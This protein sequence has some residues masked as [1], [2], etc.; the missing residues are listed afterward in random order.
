[1]RAF[2]LDKK[3]WLS[4]AILIIAGLFLWQ[5][6]DA[7]LIDDLK[8]VI[9]E[10]N[11]QIQKLEEEAQRYRREIAVKQ[12]E[13]QT[14]RSEIGQI[15]QVVG[16]LKREIAVTESKVERTELELKA[17]TI[18]IQDKEITIRKLRK[19]LAG[20]VLAFFES[21]QKP[22]FAILIHT[23]VLSDF[24]RQLDYLAFLE[25][26]ILDSLKSIRTIKRDLETRKNEVEGK[27]TELA[28]LKTSLYGKKGVQEAVRSEQNAI[29]KSTKNEEEQY[30]ALLKEQEKKRALLE[31]EI[32]SI[33]E[34]IRVTIDPESLPPKRPGI[35]GYPLPDASK[36]SCWQKSGS[37]FENCTTQ[38]FGYTA[39]A[40]AG[41]Y[42]SKGHNGTDFR[43]DIGTPVRAAESAIVEAIGNTDIGCRGASYGKWILLRHPN[44][45]STLYAHLS[46]INVTQGQEMKRRERIGYSGKSG[47]AT[48]PHLHF[49]VLVTKAVEIDTIVSRVCGRNMTLPI[50]GNDPISGIEGY[51]DP[52]D[53]L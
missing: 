38:F 34:K 36:E 22:L 26:K 31:E 19:G 10:R 24:F 41:G 13:V 42:A 2:L 12:Y 46:T 53:Y 4:G 5:V 21:N 9:E 51:L 33:E 35:L 49:S 20:L 28:N 52:F 18:E 16:R 44:N 45:I 8:K 6:S 30:Q 40:K 43:A 15:N 17:L 29:L 14:L 3:Q 23:R 39:F 25:E 32:R 48:G 37:T 47:Y 27:R 11:V 7:G 50:A 1:V